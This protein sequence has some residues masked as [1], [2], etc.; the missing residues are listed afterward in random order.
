MNRCTVFCLLLRKLQVSAFLNR[1]LNVTS[2][3]L[4][5]HRN[6]LSACLY[7]GAFRY[8]FIS[9]VW[10]KQVT[11][12]ISICCPWEASHTIIHFAVMATYGAQNPQTIALYTPFQL[13]KITAAV[14]N[15]YGRHG[16]QLDFNTHS[17]SCIDNSVIILKECFLINLVPTST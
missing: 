15:A 17:V 6:V 2:L 10:M 8:L 13:A 7:G 16:G 9:Q 14:F 4:K 11:S 1:V 12:W 5:W 3:F